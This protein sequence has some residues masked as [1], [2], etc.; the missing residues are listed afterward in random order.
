M[1]IETHL[2][3]CYPHATNFMTTLWNKATMPF[4]WWNGKIACK[5]LSFNRS[6]FEL[7]LFSSFY[8][9]VFSV[10]LF[11][12]KINENLIQLKIHE[13]KMEEDFTYI[14]TL[15]KTSKNVKSKCGKSI[16]NVVD[17]F[18]KFQNLKRK[19]FSYW[20]DIGAAQIDDSTSH[21]VL[22]HMMNVR[23]F[24]YQIR[25]ANLWK[26]GSLALG[27]DDSRS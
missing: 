18:R 27:R 2:K 1:F 25:K 10:L 15:L 7:L 14:Q 5:I 9:L 20:L 11:W 24:T 3:K 22:H 4:S 26:F 17:L 16:Q 8:L 13:L 19:I 21:V 12:K 6:T 23:S